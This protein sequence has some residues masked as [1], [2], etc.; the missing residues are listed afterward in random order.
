MSSHQ[1][2]KAECSPMSGVGLWWDG[3]LEKASLE[4]RVKKAG[5]MDGDSGN[6]GV[7]KC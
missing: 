7:G 1:S 6:D 2:M 5:T 4:F 3:F